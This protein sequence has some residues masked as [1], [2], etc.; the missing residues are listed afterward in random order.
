MGL[1]RALLSVGLMTYTPG[2][3]KLWPDYPSTRAERV[4]AVWWTLVSWT[5]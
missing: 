1:Q 3:L 4:T 2:S 5:A